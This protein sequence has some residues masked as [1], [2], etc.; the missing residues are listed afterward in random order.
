MHREPSVRPSLGHHMSEAKE[1][2]RRRSALAASLSI[3]GRISAEFDQSRFLRMKSQPELGK[4]PL[5]CL[6]AGFRLALVLK[7]QHEVI[8]VS[9][10]NN[11]STTAI[12]PPLLNPQ[13]KHVV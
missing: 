10:N 9:Y 11:I 4:T 6:Q 5:E 7:S 1:V 12:V 2:E 3:L 13:V 8:G